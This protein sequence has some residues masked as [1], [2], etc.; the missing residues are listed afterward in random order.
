MNSIYLF[1]FEDSELKCEMDYERRDP[2]CGIFTA[3]VDLYSASLNGVDIIT[4]LSDKMI[5][6][7]KTDALQSF[8]D[9]ERDERES[10]Y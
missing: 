2:S 6:E 4:L 1:C 9:N 3:S 8:I 10:D 5:S 7:I